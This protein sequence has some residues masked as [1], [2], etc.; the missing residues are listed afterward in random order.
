[1]SRVLKNDFNQYVAPSSSTTLHSVEGWLRT[2]IVT[3]ESTTIGEITIYDNTAASGDIL[4]AA[5][6]RIDAPLII[7]HFLQIPMKFD[8]GLTV[9]TDA[10]ANAFLLTEI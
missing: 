7:K 3:G 4:F 6:V 9:V 8:T 2:L 10:N 5:K 1:M